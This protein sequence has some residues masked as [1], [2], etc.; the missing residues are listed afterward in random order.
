[1]ATCIANKKFDEVD[2]AAEMQADS[3]VAD[4]MP[5]LVLDAVDTNLHTRECKRAAL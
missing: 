4:L 5:T 3:S 1:M 2:I